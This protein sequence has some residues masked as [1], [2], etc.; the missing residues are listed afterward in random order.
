MNS[1]KEDKL[2]ILSE[3]TFNDYVKY[4]VDGEDLNA[5]RKLHSAPF[6]KKIIKSETYDILYRYIENSENKSSSH[7][8]ILY[9]CPIGSKIVLDLVSTTTS[10]PKEAWDEWFTP[11]TDVIRIKNARGIDVQDYEGTRFSWEKEILT[12]GEFIIRSR[13]KVKTSKCDYNLITIE[14][15]DD[16]RE[17]KESLLGLLKRKFIQNKEF[18]SS[19]KDLLRTVSER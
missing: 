10:N 3:S 5:I 6:Y 14:Y 9:R 15:V 4:W 11:G 18:K 12:C 16:D 1:L 2:Y 17:Q 8:S 19:F 7:N 13:K